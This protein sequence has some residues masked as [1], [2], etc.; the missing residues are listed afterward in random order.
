VRNEF[1]DNL[2]GAVLMFSHE[3]IVRDNE[4]SSNRAGATGAG[5]LLKDNDNLFVEGNRLMRNKFGMTVEGTPQTAGTTAIFRRN[6]FAL[7]DV[8]IAL[9]STSPITFVEN[10]VID[11]VVQ[12][13]ALSGS[14]AHA[15]ADADAPKDDG[16]QLPRG[17][18]WTSEGR[19]NYW[20]D[21]R[22]FDADGDGVGDQPYL[23]RPAFAGRLTGDP[24][25]Q[26]FQYTV[27]QQAI[28]LAADMFPI[29]RY[30]AVIEDGGPLMKPPEGL[31]MPHGEGPNVPLLLA[32]GALAAASAAAIAL[33]AGVRIR[34]ALGARARPSLA[35]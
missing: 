26:L 17:A 33:L 18:A 3:L 15:P 7:N 32:S 30:D 27:A 13:K 4:F 2:A 5:M 1:F 6:L 22:G 35:G 19:G 21:Y 14:I 12:V 31:G 16:A 34:F 10:A 8:G 9:T 23:P 28:D 24:T 25:L 29:F 11:N 20:S